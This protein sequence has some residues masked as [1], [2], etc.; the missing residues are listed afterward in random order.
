MSSL[1]LLLE[2]VVAT[3]PFQVPVLLLALL[4][5]LGWCLGPMR[6]PQLH[7]HR[8]R[9]ATRL[10]PAAAAV[11]GVASSLATCVASCLFLA[12][13]A[14]G[15]FTA[16]KVHLER[17][18]HTMAGS[19]VSLSSSS[20]DGAA[21]EGQHSHA[22]ELCVY[23]A[24]L[25]V[26]LCNAVLAYALFAA[27]A[28]DDDADKKKGAP[29][30]ATVSNALAANAAHLFGCFALS[31]IVS[32][33]HTV[34]SHALAVATLCSLAVFIPLL[35]LFVDTELRD[36]VALEMP[37]L[38]ETINAMFPVSKA[39]LKRRQ[40]EG[41]ILKIKQLLSSANSKKCN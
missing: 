37:E 23:G 25:T 38:A 17:I 30:T 31:L 1:P 19:A 21:P 6:N 24:L 16:W 40:K 34:V 29:R 35:R 41:N 2:S 26:L 15:P 9:R 22:A 32:E 11:L 4:G 36:I 20:S 39:E 28:V 3:L 33:R 7:L 18:A 5:G 12:E 14:A 27:D 13:S 10:S 8:M